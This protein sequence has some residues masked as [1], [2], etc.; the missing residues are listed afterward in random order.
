M[1]A[2]TNKIYRDY[3]DKCFILDKDYCHSEDIWSERLGYILRNVYPNVNE[4]VAIKKGNAANE[5][6]LTKFP[7]GDVIVSWV[8][9]SDN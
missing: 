1:F 8:P 4:V 9:R 2:T 3:I 6:I 5:V 7:K